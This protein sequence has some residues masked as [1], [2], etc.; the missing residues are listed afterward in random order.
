MNPIWQRLDGL[1]GAAVTAVFAERV[2]I[3]PRIAA[4][5]YLA[6]A[7]DGA[8][9]EVIIKAVFTL[10][11]ET[12]DLRGQRVSG[13]GR[14]TTRITVSEASLQITASQAALIGYALA[15]DDL[16]RLPDRAGASAYAIEHVDL[17]NCGDLVVSLVAEKPP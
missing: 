11:P 6:A 16:I 7:P 3:S 8:R 15:K 1:A 5:Q 9:G 10:G 4:S 2:R 17:L 13:E 14:G 12:D